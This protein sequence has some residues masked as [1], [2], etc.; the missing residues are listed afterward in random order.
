MDGT[1]FLAILNSSFVAKIFKILIMSKQQLFFSREA[2]KAQ[3][4]FL[5]LA[6]PLRRKGFFFF[7]QRR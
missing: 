2:A 1:F 6:K 7:S 3:R 4:V 5:F